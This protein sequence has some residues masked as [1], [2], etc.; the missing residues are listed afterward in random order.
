MFPIRDNVPCITTPYILR[1]ILVINALVF[2][3]E[4]TL[5]PKGKLMLFHLLGVVPARYFNPEWAVAAGYPGNGA[6]PLLTYMFLHSGWLHIILNLWMLWIFADN[7]E[8][9]TGHMRFLFFYLLCG[10]IA[11]TVQVI[12][13]PTASSPVIGASGAVAGIMGAYLVLYPHGKVLTL[14]P[15]IIIPIFIKLPASLF[16]GLWFA[17]Q[18]VSGLSNHF[19]ESAQKVAWAAHIGGFIAGLVLIRFFVRKDRCVYC[20]VAEKKDYELPDDF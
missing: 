14:F 2:L 3:L 9:A 7:I 17:L 15:I 12:F 4:Q 5:T 6:L 10:L 20:Y 19:V 16:L 13:N 8:D 18:I 1:G 11:I